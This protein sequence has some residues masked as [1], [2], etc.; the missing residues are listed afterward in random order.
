MAERKRVRLLLSCEHAS[1]AIPPRWRPLFRG[2]AELV[3]SHRGWDPGALHVA[4]GFAR[5]LRAPL[6]AGEISRLL[7]ELNRSPRS[8]TLFS[9]ITRPLPAKEKRLI[10]RTHYDSYRG[11]FEERLRKALATGESVLHLSLHSFTPVHNG[12]RRRVDLG[13]L[14]DPRRRWELS[15]AQAWREELVCALPRLRIRRNEPYRGTSDG[16]T[17]WL[18]GRYPDRQYAGIELELNQGLLGADGRPPTGLI[19]Q[20]AETFARTLDS[21]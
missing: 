13:I 2:H 10:L 7:V 4:K 17:T 8:P 3:A 16:F 9:A 21:Q 11:P 6:A 1:R 12:L 14:H 19:G 20:L 5:R 18:R 15:V